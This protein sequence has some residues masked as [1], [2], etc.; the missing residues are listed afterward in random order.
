MTSEI[1]PS[2]IFSLKVFI[3]QIVAN[4][5][6]YLSTPILHSDKV[7]AIVTFKQ[8]TKHNQDLNI[9]VVD[10]RST[11]NVG[12]DFRVLHINQ[13]NAGLSKAFKV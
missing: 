13:Y 9:D 5:K 8:V 6:V 7:K 3:L 10:N 2:E 4:C 11:D 12:L 1:G